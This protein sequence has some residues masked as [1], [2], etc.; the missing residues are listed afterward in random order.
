MNEATQQTAQLKS[1]VNSDNLADPT[2]MSARERQIEIIS[3]RKRVLARE[4]LPPEV[5][6]RGLALIRADRNERTG[7]K[8]KAGSRE[9]KAAP[10]DLSDF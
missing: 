5:L 2:T 8:P 7:R 4:E 6:R 10:F 3:I 1:E 9:P